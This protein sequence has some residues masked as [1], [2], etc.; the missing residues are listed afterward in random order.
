MMSEET[1]ADE[2]LEEGEEGEE[3][4]ES[5][6]RFSGKFIVLFIVAPLLGLSLIGGGAYFFL[7]SGGDGESEEHAQ[8]DAGAPPVFYELPEFLVNLD[9]P[10]GVTKYLKLRVSLE[11]ADAEVGAHLDTVMPRVNDEFQVYLRELRLE[12]LKG[13]AGSIRLKEELLRRINL[14]VQPSSVNDILFQ[15]MVVQ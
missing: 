10:G 13:S 8:A 14:V 2:E 15:E 5:G 7:F 6:K 12:D 3:G 11:V 1:E 4:A 9:S